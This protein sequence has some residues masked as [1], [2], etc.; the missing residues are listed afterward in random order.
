MI[1]NLLSVILKRRIWPHN[2]DLLKIYLFIFNAYECFA[3]LYVYA[4]S[5]C[6]THGGLKRVADHQDLQ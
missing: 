5:A 3:L 2:M 1:P 6:N 4:Q